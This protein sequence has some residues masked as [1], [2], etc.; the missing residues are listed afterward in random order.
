MKARAN[1]YAIIKNLFCTMIS[2][3]LLEPIVF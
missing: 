2:F 1:I 3:E